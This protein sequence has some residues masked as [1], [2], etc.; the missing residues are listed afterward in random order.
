MIRPFRMIIADI[1]QRTEVDNC[2][3]VC[4]DSHHFFVVEKSFSQHLPEWLFELSTVSLPMNSTMTDFLRDKFPA[5]TLID[6]F[7]I[8]DTW[9]YIHQLHSLS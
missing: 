8:N 7:I 5:Y 6:L 3:Y 2:F 9:I 4:Q 1:S